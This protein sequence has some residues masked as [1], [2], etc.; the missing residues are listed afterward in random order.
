MNLCFKEKVTHSIQ[1]VLWKVRQEALV[2]SFGDY[3][4]AVSSLPILVAFSA[5]GL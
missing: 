3:K 1:A 5:K 2:Y 4:A